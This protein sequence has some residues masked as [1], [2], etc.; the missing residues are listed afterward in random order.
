M[1]EKSQ[2]EDGTGCVL[3]PDVNRE[4]LKIQGDETS[5]Q[6]ASKY[7]AD[8]LVNLE[9][10][11]YEM[12]LTESAAAALAKNRQILGIIE[13]QSGAR[14]KVQTTHHTGRDRTKKGTVLCIRGSQTEVHAARQEAE[15]QE[16][17][18]G[19]L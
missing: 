15:Q 8:L 1:Q 12:H 14:L 5:V 4:V 2:N 13:S 3:I 11:F 10:Q 19:C 7:V 17:V 9:K 6:R 16:D 18:A